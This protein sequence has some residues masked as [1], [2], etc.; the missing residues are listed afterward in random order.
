MKKGDRVKYDRGPKLS[1][2][3]GI[4]KRSS[5]KGGWSIV[6]FGDSVPQG[7]WEKNPGEPKY[8]GTKVSNK[9]LRLF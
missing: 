5:S 8:P 7:Y 1:P 4:V 3:E 9:R 2:I 6:N